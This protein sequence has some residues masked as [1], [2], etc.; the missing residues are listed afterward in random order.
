[1]VR[2]GTA[3]AEDNQALDSA[4]VA[5]FPRETV[6][7]YVHQSSRLTCW[8]IAQRC[9]TMNPVQ[10]TWA[11]FAIF[12]GMPTLNIFQ[13]GVCARRGRPASAVVGGCSLTG[14]GFYSTLDLNTCFFYSCVCILCQNS[15]IVPT[16][17]K[18][19][20]YHVKTEIRM[21]YC[22]LPLYHHSSVV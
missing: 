15:I 4:E 13:P 20:I 21:L 22:I 12:L 18:K 16:I 14:I 3:T 7:L 9:C 5:S 17:I 2:V 1:M 8:S 11:A 19:V 6:W 10:L